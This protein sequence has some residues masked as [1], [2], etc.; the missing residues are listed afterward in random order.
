MSNLKN[1]IDFKVYRPQFE[2][3][4][5]VFRVKKNVHCVN[6]FGT[7]H[8]GLMPFNRQVKTCKFKWR[9]SIISRTTYRKVNMQ[10][11]E[12]SVCSPDC[13][14]GTLLYTNQ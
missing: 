13:F 4:T 10:S 9:A 5:T 12:G 8:F 11:K 3:I 7:R 6:L 14:N 1:S 2:I